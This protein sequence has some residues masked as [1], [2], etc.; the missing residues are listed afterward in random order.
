M[1]VAVIETMLSAYLYPWQSNEEV[2]EEKAQGRILLSQQK[3]ATDEEWKQ[4]RI[5]VWAAT[6]A[7]QALQPLAGEA[8]G[9]C[10]HGE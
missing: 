2:E 9:F 1:L 7:A 10:F 3:D 5:D 8:T 4:S 6:D